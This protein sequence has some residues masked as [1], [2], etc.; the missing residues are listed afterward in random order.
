MSPSTFQESTRGPARGLI[1]SGKCRKMAPGLLV[2]NA[3][4][5]EDN[6]NRK[7]IIE[8]GFYIQK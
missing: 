5:P 7:L 4:S 3:P 6:E 1:V 8:I 2:I